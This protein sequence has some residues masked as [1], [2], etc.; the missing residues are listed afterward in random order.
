MAKGDVDY[1]K[2]GVAVL[3]FVGLVVFVRVM[4]KKPSQQEVDV[5]NK[6]KD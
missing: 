4:I 5:Y 2:V 3:G 1:V 6:T